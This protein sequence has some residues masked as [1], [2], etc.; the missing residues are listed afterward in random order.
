M[1]E[2]DV[3]V[4]E[5]GGEKAGGGPAGRVRGPASPCQPSSPPPHPTQPSLLRP[6]KSSIPRLGQSLPLPL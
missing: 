6:E 1:P 4:D 3:E 2:E 5:S